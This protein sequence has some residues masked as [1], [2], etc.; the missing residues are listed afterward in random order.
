MGTWKG[1]GTRD[2]RNAQVQILTFAVVFEFVQFGKVDICKVYP[3]PCRRAR[4]C[5][6]RSV[7]RSSYSLSPTRF[8]VEPPGGDG[9]PTPTSVMF[10]RGPPQPHYLLPAWTHPPRATPNPPKFNQIFNLNFN[11]F[12]HRFWTP[13]GFQF[14]PKI[15]PKSFK[16]A[17]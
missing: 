10:L 2:F 4:C 13:F 11:K 9:A 8:Q 3:P 12:F 5:V 1:L 6:T 16:S 7:E 14:R 17:S 15:V